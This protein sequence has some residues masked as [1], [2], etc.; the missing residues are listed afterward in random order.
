MSR[1]LFKLV[2]LVA[3]AGALFLLY[4]AL[5]QYTLDEVVSSTTAIPA[6]RIAAA[7]GF[8]AGSYLCLTGFDWL[9]VRYAGKPLPWRRTALASFTSL[10]IGHN[11]GIAALSSGAIRYRFYTRWGLGKA[12]V[13]KVIVFCGLTVGLG[14]STLGA[15]GLLLYPAEAERMM[16]IDGAALTALAVACLAIPAIY[17]VLAAFMR[18][19]LR[20]REWTLELPSLP[21]AAGQVAIGTVN[22]AFVAACLHQLLL[23]FSPVAYLK[24]AAVYVVANVTAIVSH[25]PGGLG[26]LEAA[27]LYLLPQSSAIGALVAFRVV[28][29]FIPLALGVPMFVASEYALRDVEPPSQGSATQP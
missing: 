18:K 4:R 27:V 14:L 28:Y 5:S 15:I 21:I 17:L 8:A 19:Q 7:I 2:I 11:I 20:F 6:P 29:F 23:A 22:F 24:V 9:A 1:L 25:V 13:A 12:D 16:A 26:V 10:S 3:I